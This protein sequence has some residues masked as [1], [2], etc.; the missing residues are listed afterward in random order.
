[1]ETSEICELVCFYRSSQ[2]LDMPKGLSLRLR[3]TQLSRQASASTSSRFIHSSRICSSSTALPQN[4]VLSL[5]DDAHTRDLSPPRTYDPKGA[6]KRKL[7]EE[8]EAMVLVR[9]SRQWSPARV[10]GQYLDVIHV[11]GVE[12]IPLRIHQQVLRLSVP[13]TSQLRETTAINMRSRMLDIRRPHASEARLQATIRNMKAAGF[14][15]TIDDYHF[16]L[17]Q[18]AAV[19]HH[20][21]AYQVLRELSSSDILLEPK[22]FGLVLQSLAHRL[23]LPCPKK[24][25]ETLVQ[26]I[27][28][29][30]RDIVSQMRERNVVISSA[31]LDLAV[32]VLKETADEEGFSHL[33]KMSYGIDLD[34]PD[35]VPVEQL[36]QE[37]SG[38]SPR[39]FPES[40]SFSTAALN[41]TIDMLGRFGNV[42][43]L[44]Q[45]FEVL[46]QPLPSQAG[47]HYSQSFEDED[48]EYGISN[49]AT[50]KLGMI[51]HVSPNTSS[52][53]FLIKHLA[54]AGH[55]PLARHYLMAAFCL[56]READ[57][58]LRSQLI[59]LPDGEVFA[60]HFAVNRGTM[61]GVF[62]LANRDKD[63]ELMRWVGWV[64]RQ[65]ARR[66]RNDI[67]YYT[68]IAAS[69]PTS[70][71]TPSTPPVSKGSKPRLDPSAK[72]FAIDFDNTPS[73]P[74][75]L[76]KKLFDI[77]FHLGLLRRDEEEISHLA[78]HIEAVL[79][80]STQRVKERLG[81]RVW[82]G[83]NIYLMSAGQRQEVS[84]GR[85]SQIVRFRPTGYRPL[86][87]SAVDFRIPHRRRFV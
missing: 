7:L 60:P 13:T 48:E 72:I 3:L 46:T 40:Q 21:G 39:V 58:A 31:N 56:D 36:Q 11:V 16:V 45:T 71:I 87:T 68:A 33:M 51:P 75:P 26:E 53:N 32:R 55:G 4:S 57:R 30:C 37:D 42:S 61:I 10:W 76:P 83:Q 6:L 65:T 67:K 54:R 12:N 79:S 17:S 80:R 38:S 19:G 8:L 59:N 69:L 84:R 22:T 63:L 2:R 73:I 70:T 15:P 18:F 9:R 28:Q 23:T 82:A 50:T 29:L 64:A 81:R 78:K 74:S 34:F 20:A 62:G 86:S 77:H 35:R 85:W 24:R 25:H 5:S 49:P 27:T 66:K 1:M 14:Q 41:T 52:Y 47:Q 44:V 43:K